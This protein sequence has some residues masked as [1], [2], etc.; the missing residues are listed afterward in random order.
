M[1][2][3]TTTEPCSLRSDIHIGET[4]IGWYTTCTR[5]GT[6]AIGL[7]TRRAAVDTAARH[8]NLEEDPAA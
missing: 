3:L 4:S 8:C 5:H 1:N 6:I 7:D 2:N